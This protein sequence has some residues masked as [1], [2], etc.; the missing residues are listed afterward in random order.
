V[1]W[2][3]E[4]SY[5]S[6]SG[7]SGPGNIT[8]TPARHL[9]ISARLFRRRCDAPADSGATDRS[10]LHG[11]HTCELSWRSDQSCERQSRRDC[12][13]LDGGGRG[14]LRFGAWCESSGMQ[15]AS[16]Y[17]RIRARGR[18][19]LRRRVNCKGEAAGA[20]GLRRRRNVGPVRSFA[21]REGA[22]RR[23]LY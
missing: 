15:L 11:R 21:A 19:T 6:A 1:A 4:G 10:L 5:L 16:R 7:S 17:R 14:S 12:C 9:G 13:W 18:I 22:E 3:Q 8:G 2:A 20:A 23:P